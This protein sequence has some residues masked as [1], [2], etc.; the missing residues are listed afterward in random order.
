MDAKA[1]WKRV[2]VQSS[3]ECWE[4]KL[5]PNARYGGVKAFGEQGAHRI[6]YFLVHGTIPRE[7]CVLHTCDNPKC[8]NPEHLFL[9]TNLVNSLDMKAKK[10][11]LYGER[12]RNARLDRQDAADIRALYGA[13]FKQIDL[14]A[15]YGVAQTHISRIVNHVQWR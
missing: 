9:G 11:Q 7:L 3:T 15:M 14:A 12:N 1:F 10:R 5:T 4:W 13:G 6:A 8:C 2:N